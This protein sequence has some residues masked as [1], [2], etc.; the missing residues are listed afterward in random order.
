MKRAGLFSVVLLALTALQLG[1]NWLS[2]DRL[3]ARLSLTIWLLGLSALAAYSVLLS[4]EPIGS[5]L[6]R[7]H[8]WGYNW[9]SHRLFL[10]IAGLAAV[11][12][13]AWYTQHV[14]GQFL[15]HYDFGTFFYRHVLLA[16]IAPRL[17]AYNPMLNGGYETAELVATGPI[18]LFLLT[19]PTSVLVSVE[20]AFK[21]QP[22]L[23]I[24]LLPALMY[25]SGRLLGFDHRASLLPAA[26][27]LVMTPVG[28]SGL[29]QMLFHGTL[30]YVFSSQLAVVVFALGCRVFVLGTGARW[31]L[32]LIVLSS[33]LGSLHPVFFVIIGPP[34]VAIVLAGRVSLRKK[35][36]FSAVVTSGLLALNGR[37]IGQLLSHNGGELVSGRVNPDWLSLPAWLD[38]LEQNFLGLPVA[39]VIGA[40]VGIRQLLVPTASPLRRRLGGLLFFAVAYCTLLS[41]FGYFFVASLQPMRFIVPLSFFLSLALAPAW[42]VVQALWTRVEREAT[43]TAFRLNAALGLLAVF[44]C[45]PYALYVT[46]FP[47]APASVQ[48]LVD[49]LKQNARSGARVF[50]YVP[51]HGSHDTPLLAQLP[52]Y[53]IGSH[54][55]L[56]GVA[57]SHQQRAAVDWIQAIGECLRHPETAWTCRDLYNIGYAVS[58][59]AKPAAPGAAGHDG[60][61]PGFTLVDTVGSIHIYEAEDSSGYFLEGEGEVTQSVNRISVTA[62]PAQSVV[63]K[64]FWVPGLRT[65]PPLPIEPFPIGNGRAFIRVR[66]NYRSSFDIVY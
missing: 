18:N 21:M 5:R 52:F 45:L 40:A 39:L 3:F 38:K 51:N 28:H 46:G 29:M 31:A 9:L 47:V 13:G 33:S 25:L 27:A 19:Y 66:A 32:P 26:F 50:F 36:T 57:G 61:P 20:A 7:L 12:F 53:Q 56:M 30:P 6:I 42:P 54:R 48:Q 60:T 62:A 43:P 59:T 64:F 63:L 22:L 8:R 14:W 23:I 1:W 41:S 55:P 24:L 16:Q 2:D 4:I 65:E 10:T 37:P 11:A 17:V 15:V 49:W 44:L 35:V 34:A 58:F